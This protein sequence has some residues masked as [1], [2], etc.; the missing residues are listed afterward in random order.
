M[1]SS[2]NTAVP[3]T[4]VFKTGLVRVLFVK[5]SVVALPTSVSVDT[6]KVKVTLPEYAECAADCSC[7]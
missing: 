7:V 4:P 1:L 2:S 3:E 5:V 6:G